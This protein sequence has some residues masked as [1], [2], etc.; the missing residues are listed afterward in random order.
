MYDL[1]LLLSDWSFNSVVIVI[2]FVCGEL[3]FIALVVF[4]VCCVSLL[5]CLGLLVAW[6]FVCWFI[7]WLS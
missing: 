4:G 1:Y 6:R 5:M 7:T 2:S 3:V